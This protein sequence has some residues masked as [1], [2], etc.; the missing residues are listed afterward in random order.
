ME[1]S[2]R[3]ERHGYLFMGLSSLS[4]GVMGALVKLASQ[5]LPYQEVIFFRS[6]GGLVLIGA[7][8]AIAR[9]PLI[10]ND[11]GLLVWRG[12][13]GWMALACYFYAIARIPLANAVLLNYTSPFFTALLSALLLGERLTRPIVACLLLA[14][15][16]V[17]LV[18]A[19][20]APGSAFWLAFTDWGALIALGSGFFAAMAY[21]AVKRATLRNS[22][23][24]IVLVFSAVATALSVPF[25]W[26]SYRA[27]SPHEAWVLLGVAVTATLAQVCMTYGYSLA[28]ASTASTISLLT[29]LVAAMLGIAYFGDLPTWGTWVGGGMILAAGIVLASRPA[30]VTPAPE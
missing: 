11:K 13:M 28:R 27:P 16:G 24:A 17:A 26:S 29:P 5:T 7:Y 4:F 30:S 23:W 21:V 10:V 25:M 19:P 6:A 20:P 12:I 1:R 2:W 3:T 18:V 8:A 22:P 14:T 9:I 15:S